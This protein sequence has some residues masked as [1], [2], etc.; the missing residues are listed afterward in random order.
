MTYEEQ[1]KVICKKLNSEAK[2]IKK[3][4]KDEA[5]A[6]AIASLAKIGICN[7]EGQLTKLYGGKY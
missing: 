4:P 6:Y 1:S 2:K 5:K 7:N 3:M